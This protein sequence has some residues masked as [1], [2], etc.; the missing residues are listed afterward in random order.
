MKRIEIKD[1]QKTFKNY[2]NKTITVCG[3]ARTVRDSKN[4]A[5][6]E[7]NDGA[8]KSVQIVVEKE[9]LKNYEKLDSE[10][11]FL[12]F[13]QEGKSLYS[14]EPLDIND[15][16]K[17]EVDHIIPRTLIKDNSFDNKAL[18]LKE[19]NQIKAGSFVLPENFRN[20]K[21]KI[22]WQRLKD[23]NLMSSKKYNNL[24][25]FKFDNESISGFINRQLVETRQICKHVADILNNLYNDTDVI[26]IPANLSHNYREKFELFKFREINDYHHAHDAYLAAVLGEYKTKYLK[27]NID[28][29]ELKIINKKLYDEERYKE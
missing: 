6:I 4:I 10:K 28:F 5:F 22:W 7:L 13:L 3:W 12:Y 19:E 15:L 26:Y 9:K 1:L 20:N 16:D 23:L 8:F 21:M 14:G 2:A 29:E 24:C 17:Y 25:R 18:V 11:L 27:E